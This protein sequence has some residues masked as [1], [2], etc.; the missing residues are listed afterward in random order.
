MQWGCWEIVLLIKCHW[1]RHAIWWVR[2]Y[3]GRRCEQQFI[4]IHKKMNM[5]Y[6]F[7]KFRCTQAVWDKCITGE[8]KNSSE[9]VKMHFLM[10]YNPTDLWLWY[11]NSLS[12]QLIAAVP[13]FVLSWLLKL[14]TAGPAWSPKASNFQEIADTFSL[15][16]VNQAGKGNN[17]LSFSC[18]RC[19][20]SYQQKLAKR[21]VKN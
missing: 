16:F 3:R 13:A 11:L 7:P 10:Q 21:E 5:V 14:A 9:I 15:F 20:C 12:P 1:G 19:E 8:S 2:S 6:G 18:I 17:C 4:N